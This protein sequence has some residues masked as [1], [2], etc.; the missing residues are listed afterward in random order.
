VIQYFTR[1]RG[2]RGEIP[3]AGETPAPLPLRTFVT[4]AV[5]KLLTAEGKTG[6]TAEDAEDR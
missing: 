5:K 6:L 1:R 3:E 2:D 4:S